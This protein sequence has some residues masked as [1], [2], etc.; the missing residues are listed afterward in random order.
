MET[1]GGEPQ[2]R[3]A[4]MKM[5]LMPADDNNM[6]RII[7]YVFIIRIAKSSLLESLNVQ[8]YVGSEKST[9]D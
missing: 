8:T 6:M 2:K 3:L 7:K 5:I 9:M 1:G 4:K